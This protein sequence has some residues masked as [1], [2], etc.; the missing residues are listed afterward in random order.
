[1]NF[2]PES[3][4]KPIVQFNSIVQYEN[5]NDLNENN[6]IVE[7]ETQETNLMTLNQIITHTQS[8]FDLHM[9]LERI[10][11]ATKSIGEIIFLVKWKN[12]DELDLISAK[13]ANLK[14][15]NVVIEFYEERIKF[16]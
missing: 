14:C 8:Q 7:N 12:V 9:E 10:I 5:Q 3:S 11:G 13:I 16:I 1:M 4:T 15:P 6:K 2:D